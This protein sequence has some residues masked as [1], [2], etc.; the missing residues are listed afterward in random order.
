[1]TLC[2]PIYLAMS[3]KTTSGHKQSGANQGQLQ[4]GDGSFWECCTWVRTP[5]GTIYQCYVGSYTP[6]EVKIT[7]QQVERSNPLYHTLASFVHIWEINM[8]IPPFVTSAVHG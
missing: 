2:K 7:D 5:G 3:E 1:M 6:I 4:D 8:K